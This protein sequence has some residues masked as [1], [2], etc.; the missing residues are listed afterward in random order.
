[1]ADT[2]SIFQRAFDIGEQEMACLKTR[3]VEGADC[4]ARERK[5]LLDRFCASTGDA[6][7]RY[8][9][10]RLQHQQAHLTQEARTLQK[11]LKQ[12]ILRVHGQKKRYTGYRDATNVSLI[13]SHFVSRQ[14]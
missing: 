3:D 7:F 4:L 10:E 11:F 8:K 14:G 5:G 2:E 12:E 13:S 9:L 6:G 1:M